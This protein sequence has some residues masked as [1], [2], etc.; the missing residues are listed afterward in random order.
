MNSVSIRTACRV[1]LN[2]NAGGKNITALSK[3]KGKLFS[4]TQ[5]CIS[6]SSFL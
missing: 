5:P 6:G 1:A 3:M 2:D 4:Y